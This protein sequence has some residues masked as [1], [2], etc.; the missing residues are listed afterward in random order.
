MP[1]VV[2]FGSV[3]ALGRLLDCQ[4]TERLVFLPLGDQV[5]WEVVGRQA[6]LQGLMLTGAGCRPVRGHCDQVPSCG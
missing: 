6:V 5:E 3:F 4:R 2:D 1:K